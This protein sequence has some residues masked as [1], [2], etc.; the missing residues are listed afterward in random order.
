MVVNQISP[1]LWAPSSIE[2]IVVVEEPSRVVGSLDGEESRAG[3]L[4]G[5]ESRVGSL[6]GEQCRVLLW[7]T[8]PEF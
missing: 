5:G 4:D 7:D 8:V 2:I 6:N 3:F 1:Q